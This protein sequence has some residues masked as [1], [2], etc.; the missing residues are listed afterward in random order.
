MS[1]SDGSYDDDFEDDEPSPA[2]KRKSTGTAADDDDYADDFEDDADS[3]CGKPKGGNG[4]GTPKGEGKTASPKHAKATPLRAK[5]TRPDGDGGGGGSSPANCAAGSAAG[6]PKRTSA[7]VCRTTSPVVIAARRAAA[8]APT[9]QEIKFDEEIELGEMIGGGGFALVY[10]GKWRG[11]QVALKTL[12]DPRVTESVKREY[13]DELL[14]MAQLSHPNIVGLLG[15]CVKPP[16]MCMVIELCDRSLHQLL[17]QSRIRVEPRAMVLMALDVAKGMAYLH[18]QTPIV[19][20]RDLKSHNLLLTLPVRARGGVPRVKVCDFGLVS[21]R[22]TCAGTPAYMAP[23][24]LANANCFSASVDVY[25]FAVVLWE[26]MTRSVPFATFGPAEIRDHVRAGK[27][28]PLPVS[29]C[30]REVRD[31]ITRGWDGDARV[32]PTFAESAAVLE[33]AHKAMPT[34]TALRELSLG[35]SGGGGGGDA[36]DMLS[37]SVRKK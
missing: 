9:W 36:L 31:L 2:H 29:D 16:N 4:A 28:L 15:A 12:F 26:M 14:V 27:R 17:H 3:P 7:K 33:A 23:E 19:V 21:A 8:E 34:T 35:R 5:P 32:R 25:A 10:E 18:A 22:A 24:L 37:T 11:R 6:S 30:P 20:H 13:M 1:G